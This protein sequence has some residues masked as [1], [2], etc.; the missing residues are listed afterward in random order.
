MQ[1]SNDV[2]NLKTFFYSGI[3]S[4]RPMSQ[5]I[6]VKL[7]ARSEVNIIKL[8]NE[9]QIMWFPTKQKHNIPKSN[10]KWW[11]KW[12]LKRCKYNDKECVQQNPNV[13]RNRSLEV[14][15]NVKVNES[16]I[17]FVQKLERKNQHVKR[18]GTT[19]TFR[20]IPNWNYIIVQFKWI[21]SHAHWNVTTYCNFV[22]AQQ[23][24]FKFEPNEQKQKLQMIKSTD[25]KPTFIVWFS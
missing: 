8:Q 2:L 22:A 5:C 9:T 24:W 21:L 11:C 12:K 25:V 16:Q 23:L 19:F 17:K 13:N 4:C 14:K 6:V 7:Y 1:F 18:I 10:E 20:I 3:E 15:V